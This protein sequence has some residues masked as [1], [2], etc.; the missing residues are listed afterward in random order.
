[1]S[2][3]PVAA[4]RELAAYARRV[5]RTYPAEF[6]LV[7][8][9]QMLG[10]VAGL[11]VPWLLGDLVANVSAGHDTV[12]HTIVLIL[13]FLAAQSV[14]ARLAT[15]ASAALGEKILATL[16]EEFVTD[17]LALPPEVVEDADA[18][19]LITRTS[20][21]VDLLSNTVRGAIPQSMTAIGTIVFTVGAMALVS[22]LLLSVPVL[23]GGTR[24]Y[25]RR[26]HAGYLREESS[27]SRMT[28]GLAETVQGAR[29]VEALRL[30]G[31]RMDRVNADIAS[32]YAAQS[33]TRRLRNVFFPLVGA[34]YV[35]PASATLLIGGTFYLH[36]LVSLAGITAGTAYAVQ[37]V[38]PLDLLMFWVNELQ[39]AGAALAR[40]L[41]IA[42]FRETDA[43]QDSAGGTA[44]RDIVVRDLRYAYQPG[45]DALRG[46]DLTTRQGEWLAVV[47][48]SG[49]GK[50]TFAKLLA[51][52]YEPRTGSITIGGQEITRLPLAARRRKVALVTQ[53]H[54]VFR[55]TMRDNLA[56]AS[57]GAGDDELAAALTAVD[58]WEW[59][60][61]L[62]LDTAIGPRGEALDPA[63]VQQLALA[64]LILANLDTL[65]LDEATSMLNPGAARH[66]ERSLAAVTRGR[67]VIAIVHRLHT[68]RDADRIAVFS[69]GRI[70]ELGTHEDLLGQGGG[71]AA[72]WHAWQGSPAVRP[73]A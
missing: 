66:L 71:Y 5:I 49:A 20:R 73:R 45:Q 51:G 8:G 48:P 26:A 2:A 60:G 36:G 29:T 14:L 70:A 19:D 31:R 39:S 63:K 43:L 33:Y 52:I 16:R 50:S 25:L 61:R 65:I 22:P 38:S 6:G 27:Y 9:L 69:D 57:P 34:G 15:Y 41:G 3:L 1:M 40:L 54:H 18:G 32:S 4:N 58:A 67:T 10:V 7:V 68:A 53:E 24:W 21:D 46:V 23:F 12:A 42:Q 56:I 44:R 59:A 64:R 28:E 35:L 17:V 11:F 13:V 30:T 47:G 72:L 37:L 62:G 55:G